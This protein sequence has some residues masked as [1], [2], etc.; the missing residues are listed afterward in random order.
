GFLTEPERY[1]LREQG[2]WDWDRREFFRIVGGGVVIALLADRLE[3]QQPPGGRQRGGG[4]FGGNQSREIGAWLHIGE[5]SSVTVFTGKVEIGQNIRTS[6]TQV[7]AEELRTPVERISLVMADTARCPDDGGT[8]GSGSTPR[9][10]AQLR[11]VAAA[12]RE[13]ILDLAAE[14]NK[15]DRK[16]LHVES[17]RVVGPDGKTVAF[18]PLTKGKKMLREG[19]A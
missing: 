16:E 7:V 13:A 5:D 15:L 8:A 18:C 4:F 19:A 6:F 1:E 9:T 17:G 11:R 10:A 14:E 3:A 12:A 2:A